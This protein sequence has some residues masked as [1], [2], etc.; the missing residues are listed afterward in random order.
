[1][2]LRNN[3]IKMRE[4]LANHEAK[5]ILT[6]TFP[7]FANPFMLSMAEGMT[8]A[9]VIKLAGSKVPRAKIES[10]VSELEKL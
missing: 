9:A 2:D 5:G 7:E 4:L 1:M 10:V 6:R 3:T 8:L